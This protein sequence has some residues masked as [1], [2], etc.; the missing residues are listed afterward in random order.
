MLQ[1]SSSL[2]RV[3]EQETISKN[4]TSSKNQTSRIN[5]MFSN[6]GK[7]MTMIV[8]STMC[9]VGTVNAQTEPNTQQSKYSGLAIVGG[10]QNKDNPLVIVDGK[11]GVDINSISPESIESFKI[12]KDQE[13]IEK[14]GE[15]GKNGVVIITTKLNQSKKVGTPLFVVGGNTGNN[16]E[17]I[18]GVWK[19]ISASTS[20][21]IVKIIT[22]GHFTCIHILDNVIVTSFGGSYSFDGETY[23]ENI[24]FG[25]ENRND[26]GRTGTFKINF[27]NKKMYL[28]G[29][30]SGP[31]RVP[32]S[33]I[34]ER[35]E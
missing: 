34:W 33:E 7:I 35:V 18:V 11:E 19:F 5:Q 8:F 3:M 24:L 4:W 15:K 2:N 6:C 12:L 17:Q 16:T 31:N 22:K 10:K 20:K 9:V 28:S 23:I 1:Y 26:I 21:E 14:Y 13:A 27:E 30:V 32:F 29:L 25:T